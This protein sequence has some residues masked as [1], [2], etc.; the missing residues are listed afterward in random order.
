MHMTKYQRRTLD[1]YREMHTT[2]PTMGKTLV[3]IARRFWWFVLLCG[4]VSFLAYWNGW[5]LLSVA[6]LGY[7]FGL[8]RRDITHARYTIHIW[9]VVDA[10][11]DWQRVDQLLEDA[12]A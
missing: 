4:A 6:V 8:V 1:L 10:I 5:S 9:P 2:F 3:R 7:L 12:Q 11:T